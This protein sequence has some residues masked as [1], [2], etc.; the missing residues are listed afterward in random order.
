MRALK[1]LVSGLVVGIVLATSVSLFSQA[2]PVMPVGGFNR[3]TVTG[4]LLLANGTAAAPSLT[5]A[6]DPDTGI[7]SNGANSLTHLHMN[8][9]ES[10][11]AGAG[12]SLALLVFTPLTKQY[13]LGK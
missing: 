8:Q 9:A 13:G 10:T 5:F 4:K 6:S 2:G 7:F 12:L 1:A 3:L 11:A